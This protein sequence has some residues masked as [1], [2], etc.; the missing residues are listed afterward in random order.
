MK[1]IAFIGFFTLTIGLWGQDL[2]IRFETSNGLETSNYYEV[3]DFWK[4]LDVHSDKIHLFEKGPTDSGFPLH[5]ALISNSGET[6]IDKIKANNKIIILVNNGIHPGE[7]DGIDASMLLARDV[8]HGKLKLPD[9]VVLAVIPV[10]SIGGALNRSSNYRVDQNG[11]IEKASRGNGQNL[12][13]NRDYIK[14]DSKNALSFTQIFH[15]L[16]PDVFIDNHVSNGA[17]YQHIMTLLSSQHSKI[18]GEMGR[19]M[20]QQF[21]PGVYK[22]MKQKGYD[23]VPYVNVWGKTPDD[24]W[25]EFFDSPRYSSGYGTLWSTF[26]FVPETHMLKSY[27]LRVEATYQLMLSF[28]DFSSE[29]AFEIQNLRKQ[30]REI[31]KQAKSFPIAWKHDPTQFQEFLYTGFEGKTIKSEVSGLDRL[32]YDHT[33]PFEKMV[34]VYNEYQVDM[35]IEK[36]IAYLIPQAWWKVIERLQLNGVEM[37]QLDRD[38]KIEVEVY[39]IE[40]YESSSTAFESHHLNSKVEVSK[41]VQKIAFRKG[42]WYIPMNQK[43]NRF[44]VE[45]LEPQAMDSYFAWNFFDAIFQR[46]EGFSPYVFEDIAAEYLKQRPDLR[47]KLEDKKKSDPEFAQNAYAQLYFVYEHSPWIEPEFMRYPVYRLVNPDSSL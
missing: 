29:H 3:I 33:K 24:G 41:S 28:I 19:Y 17:D 14:C 42:D 13:L 7:P 40:Q 6:S 38:Q 9:Q 37:Y 45:T 1:N 8:A 25:N 27:A 43:A 20:N 36:P 47:Q 31:E 2:K 30:T 22:S 26:C 46:K 12:D 11:P 21:E 10:Y 44:L 35:T 39:K 18:G 4:Q 23:L 32:F 5:L 16:D 34:P 15:E